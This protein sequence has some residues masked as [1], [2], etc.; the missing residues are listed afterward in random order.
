MEGI[1]QL[2]MKLEDERIRRLKKFLEFTFEKISS[3]SFF[4]TPNDLES[5]LNSAYPN[6][7]KHER[8]K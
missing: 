1:K 8:A 3:D 5:V 7:V 6:Y 4:V 2:A